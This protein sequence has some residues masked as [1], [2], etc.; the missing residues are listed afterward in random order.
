MK[1]RL[2]AI[3]AV[4]LL[5]CLILVYSVSFLGLFTAYAAPNKTQIQ[6]EL[7]G[8]KAEKSEI[9]N[10]AQTKQVEI[11]ELQQQINTIQHDI[12][13]YTAKIEKMTVELNE[14]QIKETNQYDAMKLRLRTMYEDNNTTYISLLFSGES[15]SEVLSYLEI[16]KQ[17][18]EHDNNMHKEL[19]K[20]RK[21]IEEK[22]Q[23]LEDEKKVLDDKKAT[24]QQSQD[25]IK[26][27]KAELDGMAAKLT[28]QENELFNKLKAIEEEE[29]MLQRQIISGGSHSATSVYNGGA[30]AYPSGYTNVT[31]PYGYRIHPIYGVRKLHTGT[32]FGAPMGAAI[33]AAAD[34]KVITSSYY[35][36]YGNTV[37]IDHGGGMTTLYAHNS[38][39][40]VSVGQTVKRGQ[41]IA[42]CGSTGNS[43]GPHCHFE[44]R[45]NGA[46][47]D[48]MKYLK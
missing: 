28:T 11:T 3:I 2:T 34:G 29:L 41:K 14:A 36:G 43:T 5:V 32:D 16:I 7:S 12:N 47:T 18:S 20:T 37:I 31:S 15:L 21:E 48:P 38:A 46:T 25:K 42:A 27:E 30:L 33:Y 24:L 9:L 44:V 39:L 1:K 45:I 4:V 13:A 40:Y 26:A 23:V 10:K 8:V 22:K 6:N 19:E 35:G 17:M